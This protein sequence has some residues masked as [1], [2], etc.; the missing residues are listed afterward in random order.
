MNSICIQELLEKPNLLEQFIEHRNEENYLVLYGVGAGIVWY[1]KLLKK[2]SISITCLCDGVIEKKKE[3][4]FEDE[5]G[6][7]DEYMVYP[8]D[9]VCKMYGERVDY[10]I[11]APRHRKIIK[12][13]LEKFPHMGIYTFDAAPIIIQGR[14]PEI[15]RRYVRDN[16]GEF[17]KVYGVLE[18]DLS[19]KVMINCLEG[20]ITSDCD[21]YENTASDSQYFPDI[22]RDSMSEEEVFVDVGAF[23]G[24]S[25]GAFL[26]CV[27]NKFKKIIAFEPEPT[28][29]EMLKK[30]YQDSRISLFQCGCGSE[31]GVMGI[32]HSNG[33][34]GARLLNNG[35]DE[36]VKIVKLD[37]II[38]DR[39]TY[40]KMDIEG[41]EAEA[42]QGGENIIMRDVPKLAI[43]VYHKAE[44]IIEITNYLR[45][46]NPRYKF[47]M[48]HYWDCSG[49]DIVLFA[50]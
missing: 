9:T 21:C 8:L 20:Y 39:V 10:I 22:V 2:L 4:S 24:D 30:N 26:D 28:N 49:T 29:Y 17:E 7:L 42:L 44:D 40:I 11:T 5:C 32:D 19:R 48:R 3:I 35:E 43:S 33:L 50:L 15:Y 25:I 1:I 46:L 13:K 6:N 36:I 47:Y 37:D 14:M 27:G 16:A 12:E 18:D 41:M 45:K 31:N 23:D 34:E 38:K